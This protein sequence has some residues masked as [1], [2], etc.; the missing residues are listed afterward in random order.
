MTYY[1]KSAFVLCQIIMQVSLIVL[2]IDEDG[3]E[4][5]PYTR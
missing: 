4:E 2:K 5:R 1:A 3:Q